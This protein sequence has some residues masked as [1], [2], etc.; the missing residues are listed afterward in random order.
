MNFFKSLTNKTVVEQIRIVG[1]GATKLYCLIHVA[2]TYVIPLNLVIAQGSS[3]EP[4]IK[5]NDILITEKVS[6]RR[7]HLK[8]YSIFLRADLLVFH[9][10]S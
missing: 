1:W 4:L 6:V 8:T 9:F 5:N 10:L 3:M 7:Q 2:K